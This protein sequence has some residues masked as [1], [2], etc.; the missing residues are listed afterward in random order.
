MDH[1]PNT[2]H[3]PRRFRIAMIHFHALVPYPTFSS[4][5]SL[6][7]Q[8][9]G[10]TQGKR[11][12]LSHKFSKYGAIKS[13]NIHERGKKKGRSLASWVGVDLPARKDTFKAE[14]DT[15]PTE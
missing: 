8:A 10:G 3:T 13:Q 4:P 2:S 9:R 11:S 7:L 12:Q 1:I 14:S 15:I 6:R 5:I